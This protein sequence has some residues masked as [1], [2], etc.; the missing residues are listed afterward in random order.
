[1]L[2]R[3]NL[4]CIPRSELRNTHMHTHTHAT[5]IFISLELLQFESQ[6]E[7]LVHSADDV[8]STFY[9]FYV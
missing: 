3:V 5:I 9:W 1:M 6:C 8:A 2:G 4:T 7:V